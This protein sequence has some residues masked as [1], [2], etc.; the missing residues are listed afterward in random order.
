MS[1][2]P[3]MSGFVFT[4]NVR[5]SVTI[6]QIVDLRSGSYLASIVNLTKFFSVR[7]NFSFFHTLHWKL[8]KFTL[9][10]FFTNFDKR[11]FLLIK[12]IVIWRKSISVRVNSTFFLT[13][14]VASQLCVWNTR[15]SLP[16]TQFFSSNQMH[17]LLKS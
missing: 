3:K 12:L 17:E 2:C 1:P 5:I 9:A 7:E 13:A 8:R 10:V 6:K 16:A 11:T 4:L 14:A 15:N